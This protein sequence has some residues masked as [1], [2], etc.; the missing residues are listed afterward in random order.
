[1]DLQILRICTQAV[2]FKQGIQRL[3]FCDLTKDPSGW[4]HQVQQFLFF[5]SYNQIEDS[6]KLT[7]ASFHLER[8]GLQ[9]YQWLMKV[10]GK[11]TRESLTNA[12]RIRFGPSGFI[13]FTDALKKL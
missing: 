7:L 10:K 5:L 13:A 4:I 8:D 9:W 1:M 2:P 11:M 3:I 6:E 12:L